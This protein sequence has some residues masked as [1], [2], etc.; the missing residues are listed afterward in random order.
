MFEQTH[1]LAQA[2]GIISAETLILAL[3][4]L[5]RGDDGAGLAVITALSEID[6]PPDVILMDGGTPGL[7]T[8]L[9]LQGYRRAIIVDTADMGL[10]PGTWRR[11]VPGEDAQ[12]QP[13][14]MYLRGTLH[15]AGLA[16]AL[17]LGKALDILPDEVIV[18]GIQPLEIGWQPGLCNAVR[19]AVPA[20]RDAIL[21]EL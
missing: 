10:A 7:E 19:D 8:L 14:D 15:Y 6:L 16:E 20:L 12:L 2:P 9:L 21:D 17:A 4:N 11:F 13:A 5:L 1:D 3:G 18:Y